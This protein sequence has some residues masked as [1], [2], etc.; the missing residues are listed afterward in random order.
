MPDCSVTVGS[1]IYLIRPVPSFTKVPYNY[2]AMKFSHKHTVLAEWTPFL[3]PLVPGID[4]PGP[5]KHIHLPKVD[6]VLYSKF[7]PLSSNSQ[8][9]KSSV[10]DSHMHSFNDII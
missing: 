1:M 2:C 6:V 5:N 9:T 7:Q 3:R 4:V 10:T 8:A